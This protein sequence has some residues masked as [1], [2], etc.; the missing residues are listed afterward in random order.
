MKSKSATT[1][2]ELWSTLK[3]DK[4]QWNAFVDESA[5]AA[6]KHLDELASGSPEW[7][8]IRDEMVDAVI[9]ELHRQAEEIKSKRKPKKSKPRRTPTGK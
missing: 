1:A 5:R 8:E 7:L 4:K 9:E 6:A 2:A 3:A